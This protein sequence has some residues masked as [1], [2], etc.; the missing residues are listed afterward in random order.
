[1]ASETGGGGGEFWKQVRVFSGPALGWD[2][3]NS[4]SGVS[5]PKVPSGFQSQ[6]C[7]GLFSGNKAFFWGTELIPLRSLF[8]KAEKHGPFF[9]GPRGA[10]IRTYGENRG[11]GTGLK[12]V[13][14]PVGRE[15]EGWRRRKNTGPGAPLGRERPTENSIGGA[16][17]NGPNRKNGNFEAPRFGS[18]CSKGPAQAKGQPALKGPRKAFGFGPFALNLGRRKP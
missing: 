7:L 5:H 10:E 2:R 8:N 15:K 9:Q 17:G 16:R 3:A 13:P 1:L 4:V 14:S 11:L 6:C 18:V 12:R